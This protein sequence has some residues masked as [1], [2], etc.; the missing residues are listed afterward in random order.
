MITRNITA[1]ANNT[2]NLLKI[3]LRKASPSLCLPRLL[4]NVKSR[5]TATIA[6]IT[7]NATKNLTAYFIAE[8]NGNPLRSV[9]LK[10]KPYGIIINAIK[11]E[12]SFRL[13]FDAEVSFAVGAYGTSEISFGS[14][15]SF[16][17]FIL[18]T[19]C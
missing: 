2:K 12:I 4:S 8:I 13:L 17:S 7:W 19:S 18:I 5:T 14:E 1:N 10:N 9:T 6:K 16:I 15:I 11:L 3:F